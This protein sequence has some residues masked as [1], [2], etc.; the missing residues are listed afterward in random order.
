MSTVVRFNKIWNN[1]LNFIIVYFIQRQIAE[2]FLKRVKIINMA[3]KNLQ[4]HFTGSEIEE[5]NCKLQRN[6]PILGDNSHKIRSR[7]RC[8]IVQSV[9]YRKHAA[10]R[11][12]VASTK[13]TQQTL[14]A[15]CWRRY[16]HFLNTR[17]KA[18]ACKQFAVWSI[19]KV[20]KTSKSSK[21]CVKDTKVRGLEYIYLCWIYLHLTFISLRERSYCFIVTL[22]NRMSL[23]TLDYCLTR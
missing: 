6:S 15:V 21:I 17:Q 18:S 13:M 4:S 1:I 5:V 10:C 19:N 8:I 22:I 20:T 2:H 16:K 9:S 7:I 23:V 14:D 11:H 12:Y 3:K